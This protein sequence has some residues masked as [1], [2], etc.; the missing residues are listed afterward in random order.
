MMTELAIAEGSALDLDA[1]M[2]VMNKAFDP[3]YGETWT[4]AQC[5]GALSLPDAHLMI[6]REGQSALGFALFRRVL[7]EAELLLIAVRPN[8]QRSGVGAQ[9]LSRVV[10]KLKCENV[11]S[12][13]LEMRI[14][15]PAFAF[16]KRFGFDQVGQRREYYRGL[17][18]R[19]RD[20][21]TLKLEIR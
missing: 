7:D 15:N 2:T 4:V 19:L 20:A 16:Y 8:R 10:E 13:H 18:G 21:I 17:D 6:A 12:I 11:T 1:V 5:S 14:D 3:T 9:L